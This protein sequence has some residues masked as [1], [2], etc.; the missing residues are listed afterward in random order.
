MRYG[1]L[2]IALQHNKLHHIPEELMEE[3]VIYSIV[4]AILPHISMGILRL[5]SFLHSIMQILFLMVSKMK[6]RFLFLTMVLGVL[7]E[8]I[9]LLR[10]FN[11]QLIHWEITIHQ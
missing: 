8:I 1:F 2:I 11:L 7:Q 6:E 10:S 5:K 4:G 9:V 3:A